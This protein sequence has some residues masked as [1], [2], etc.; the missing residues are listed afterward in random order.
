MKKDGTERRKITPDRVLDVT[1]ISPDG[2]WIVAGVADPDPDH[3]AITKAFAVDGGKAVTLCQG[4]CFLSW[5][6]TGKFVYLSFTQVFEGT[7]ALPVLPD[8]GLPKLPATGISRKED[9][10]TAKTAAA[11]P[12]YVHS[13]VGSSVY[14]YTRQNIH[15]NL[16]R[17]QLP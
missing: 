10:P 5:D 14:A 13:G 8:L 2:R 4:Y 17:I 12:W 6:T 11:I 1:A 16:Y 9:L 3:P 7:Y 15:R